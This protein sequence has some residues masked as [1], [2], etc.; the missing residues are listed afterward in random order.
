MKL[1]LIFK[2]IQS[3]LATIIDD[4][5]REAELMLIHALNISRAQLY[6]YPEKLLSI[7]QIKHIELWLAAR[8]QGKPLAYLLQSQAFWNLEL[9]VTAA[10]LIP[11]PETEQLV[12]WV[13]AH[14]DVNAKLNV[15]DL[16][17]GSGAIAIALATECA[18]WQVIATDKSDAA[19]AVA[20]RNAHKYQASNIRFIQSDWFA[21]LPKQSFDLIVSNPPYIAEQDA[22]LN[23]LRFEP[24]S[25]LVAGVEG[26]DAIAQIVRQ[27]PHHLN[28]PGKLI[29]EHGFDQGPAVRN[30]M[31][32]A[33]LVEV[34]TVRDL[35]GHERFSV[36][37]V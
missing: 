6:T 10:T 14:F 36:A 16:G 30:L 19:L 23:D 31:R 33:G 18:N 3:E 13:L 21:Q 17:T 28:N 37:S 9:E 4:A 20:K 35:S 12:E 32:A 29:I 1:K 15:V 24:S 5:H 8:L 25:A 22:H 7:E 34:Q 26:L 11:R 27:A 2:K